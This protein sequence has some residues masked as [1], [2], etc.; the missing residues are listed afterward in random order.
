MLAGKKA[1]KI[2]IDFTRDKEQDDNEPELDQDE[3]AAGKETRQNPEEAFFV[4]EMLEYS[5][6]GL[7]G[8]S[9][10]REEEEGK[11]QQP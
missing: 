4:R 10:P 8:T 2:I 1:A 7:L 5:E 9:W 6:E 11:G 3:K